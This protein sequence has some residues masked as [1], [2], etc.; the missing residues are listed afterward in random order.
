MMNLIVKIDVKIF[1]LR[2]DFVIKFIGK[3]IYN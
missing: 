2:I 1:I 3:S